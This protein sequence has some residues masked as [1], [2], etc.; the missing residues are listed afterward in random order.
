M[1]VDECEGFGVRERGRVIHLFS[2]HLSLRLLTDSITHHF[3]G[4]SDRFSRYVTISCRNL[5]LSFP[6]T[7]T[8]ENHSQSFTVL[9]HHPNYSF[10]NLP[11]KQSWI[12]LFTIVAGAVAYVMTDDGF[13]V[14]AYIWVTLYFI[15]SL[16]LRVASD[17]FP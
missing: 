11:S 13:I 4:N 9:I 17:T 10:Q 15:R 16:W 8:S 1:P 3:P 5:R 14:T 12:S 7:G 6:W 2:H